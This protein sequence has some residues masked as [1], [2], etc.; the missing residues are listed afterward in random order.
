MRKA[1]QIVEKYFQINEKRENIYWE[2]VDENIPGIE[3]CIYYNI[4]QYIMEQLNYI[5]V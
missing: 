1:F 3:D 4:A 2:K 5:Y